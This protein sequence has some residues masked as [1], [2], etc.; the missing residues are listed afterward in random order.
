MQ[1][2]KSPR[3][4]YSPQPHHNSSVWRLTERQK[5]LFEADYGLQPAFF[6]QDTKLQRSLLMQTNRLL[7][8]EG[9]WKLGYCHGYSSNPSFYI[10]TKLQKYQ[11][12]KEQKSKTIHQH[13]SPNITLSNTQP[14]HGYSSTFSIKLHGKN[15]KIDIHI[16]FNVYFGWIHNSNISNVCIRWIDNWT[17]DGLIFQLKRVVALSIY[18]QMRWF[19]PI[20]VIHVKL[21]SNPL[22]VFDLIYVHIYIIIY[23]H[24][25][26]CY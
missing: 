26:C 15:P 22:T 24:Q 18:M 4:L 2:F 21:I 13:K 1:A 23:I 8:E 19:T 7:S 17:L 12:T 25:P 10:N 16:S 6:Q 14:I 20:L 5:L 11:N 3:K 9:K